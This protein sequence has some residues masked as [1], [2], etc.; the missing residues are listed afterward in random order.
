M[1]SSCEFIFAIIFDWFVCTL[2]YHGFSSSLFQTSIKSCVYSESNCIDC[3]NWCT[4]SP[5]STSHKD[6][7]WKIFFWWDER[8]F[9]GGGSLPYR[10]VCVVFPVMYVSCSLVKQLTSWSATSC[11]SCH[12]WFRNKNVVTYVFF[13]NKF[14]N[15]CVVTSL[16]ASSCV[17][18]RQK[19]S[20]KRLLFKL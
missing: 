5:T 7:G 11:K 8:F 4:M 17:T 2:N 6:D 12:V 14:L 9:K 1:L 10:K 19:S 20:I 13:K 16:P 3:W 15:K 18:L